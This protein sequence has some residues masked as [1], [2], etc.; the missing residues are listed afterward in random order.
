VLVV[1][2]L[3]R[4]DDRPATSIAVE[5][6]E[7]EVVGE[8]VRDARLEAIELAERIL[9]QRDEEAHPKPGPTHRLRELDSERA[10]PGLS[11]VVEEVL[12]DAVQ[13]DV[14]VAVQD[15]RP[16]LEAIGKR[17]SVRH[18]DGGAPCALDGRRH[19]LA[20]SR[21]RIVPPAVEDRDGELRLPVLLD[22][23]PGQR[24]QW[25]ATP[26]RSTELFPT[27]VSP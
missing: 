22:V 11:F 6:V 12:L 24:A 19:G 17:S 15:L 5:V 7:T 27:P 25:C 21:H 3:D 2:P 26:A 23:P 18:G 16:R 13:D 9:P 20:E 1:E 8:Q 10:R 14:K 4:P